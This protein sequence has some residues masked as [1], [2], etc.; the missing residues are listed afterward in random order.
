MLFLVEAEMGVLLWEAVRPRG[1]RSIRVVYATAED[2]AVCKD[3]M[4]AI[5]EVLLG[6]AQMRNAYCTRVR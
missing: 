1:Y 5:G 6:Y 3:A 4:R 2:M